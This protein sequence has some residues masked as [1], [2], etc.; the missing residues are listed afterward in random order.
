[1]PKVSP[2]DTVEY[3]LGH[4][5]WTRGKLDRITGRKA[6]KRYWVKT[7][8]GTVPFTGREVRRGGTTATGY[9]DPGTLTGQAGGT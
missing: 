2:G 9:T 5:A 6:A 4:A 1:M 8:M 3:R 7:G